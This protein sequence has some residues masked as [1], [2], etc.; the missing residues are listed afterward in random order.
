MI[1]ME[2]SK[3]IL[4]NNFFVKSASITFLRVVDLISKIFFLSAIRLII[5]LKLNTLI[6][7][8]LKKLKHCSEEGGFKSL[9]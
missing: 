4:S 9:K 1:H 7:L 3:I 6:F 5:Y 8:T 2:R